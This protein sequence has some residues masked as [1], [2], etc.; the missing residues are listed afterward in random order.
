[1]GKLRNYMPMIVDAWAK[2]SVSTIMLSFRQARII[3]EQLNTDNSNERDSDSD[4]T[5][6]RMLGVKITQL[7]NSDID[8]KFDGFLEE[9]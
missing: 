5:D 9:E 8:K 6:P 3:T 4:E 2:I 1:M 7:L